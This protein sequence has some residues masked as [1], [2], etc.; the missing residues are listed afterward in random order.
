MP[1][2]AS[3]KRERQYK[4]IKSKIAKSGR[5]QGRGAEVA[6]RMVNQ[7]RAEKGET[8]SQQVSGK[9]GKKAAK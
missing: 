6:A 8:K 3:P 5:Y 2:G 9:R 7:R 1:K 4:N